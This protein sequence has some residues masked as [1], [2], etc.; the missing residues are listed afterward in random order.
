MRDEKGRFVKGHV[1]PSKHKQILIGSLIGWKI[2][3]FNESEVKEDIILNKL[4]G[5][6]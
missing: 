1:M 6:N 3:F 4:Q 5:G 2:I